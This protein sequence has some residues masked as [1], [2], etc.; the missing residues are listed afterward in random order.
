[1]AVSLAVASVAWEVPYGHGACCSQ[2]A[3]SKVTCVS[4]VSR[5]RGPPSSASQ[6]NKKALLSLCTSSFHST[7]TTLFTSKQKINQPTHK[8]PSNKSKNHNGRSQVSLALL[9]YLALCIWLTCLQ[10]TQP[11]RSPTPSRGQRPPPP[12]RATRVCS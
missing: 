1:M 3:I 9:A 4:D 7:S 10:G 12:R 5:G 8:Q 6:V 2:F 11:T